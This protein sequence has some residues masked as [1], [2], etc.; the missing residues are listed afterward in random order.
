M[1]QQNKKNGF[2]IE[3]K[4]CSNTKM[5]I[6]KNPRKTSNCIKGCPKCNADGYI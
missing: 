1:W 6:K 5:P 4:A 3:W 2:N